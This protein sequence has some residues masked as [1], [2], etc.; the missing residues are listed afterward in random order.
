M[1]PRWTSTMTSIL[2]SSHERPTRL[3]DD[4]MQNVINCLKAAT[5]WPG[6]SRAGGSRPYD[7]CEGGY[8]NRLFTEILNPGR[9]SGK[10]RSSSAF[11]MVVS[12]SAEKR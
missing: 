1:I 2:V 7:S 8:S 5:G 10:V 4:L 11:K 12:R 3:P 6:P 9:M